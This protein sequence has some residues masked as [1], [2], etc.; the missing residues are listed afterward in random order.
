MPYNIQNGPTKCQPEA[1]EQIWSHSHIWPQSILQSYQY[2]EKHGTGI[3]S[4]T[5][6]S[7]TNRKSRNKSLYV[8]TTDF[9]TRPAGSYIG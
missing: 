7:E 2:Q 3:K 6:V 5:F 8:K 9:S 4:D 1:K